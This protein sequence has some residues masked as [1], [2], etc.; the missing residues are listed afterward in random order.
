MSPGS[1]LLTCTLHRAALSADTAA[2]CA[3]ASTESVAA[4]RTNDHGLLVV[5]RCLRSLLTG[6]EITIA[7]P[8]SLSDKFVPDDFPLSFIKLENRSMKGPVSIYIFESQGVILLVC[9]ETDGAP[10]TE[11]NGSLA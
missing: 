7:H 5:T 4:N 1:T 8:C 6:F 3:I 2:G 10:P 9:K 11:R